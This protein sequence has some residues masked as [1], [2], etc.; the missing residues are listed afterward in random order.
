M[1]EYHLSLKI[2]TKGKATPHFRYITATEKYAAKRGVVHV[3]NGNMPMWAVANPSL[4]WEASDEFE[5]ANGTSYRELEVALPRE[6]AL[7]MQIELARQ[8][9]SEV[10]GHQHAYSFAIHHTKASD[11]GL[12]PHV[13]LQFSE[14][15]QDGVERDMN[16]FFKRANKKAPEK[17]GCVKDRSWQAINQGRQ[18]FGAEA[19]PRL[20]D[21][22]ANWA[23]MCNAA[24]KAHGS[25]ERVDHRSYQARGINNLFPQPKVGAKSWHLH[26]RIGMKNE[27]FSAREDVI[28]C[29]NAIIAEINAHKLAHT[30]QRM[31]MAEQE[32]SAL[33]AVMKPDQSTIL[34]TIAE[35]HERVRR[36]A[37]EIHHLEHVIFPQVYDDMMNVN[38]KRNAGSNWVVRAFNRLYF[39]SRHNRLMEAHEDVTAQ[40]ASKVMERK[41]LIEGLYQHP[42]TIRLATEQ[43]AKLAAQYYAYIDRRDWLTQEIESAKRD[44]D[45]SPALPQSHIQ[46]VKSTP[47]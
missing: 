44:I 29:N 2:G 28:E 34:R 14:R 1:A 9:A 11:G 30:E 22:R 3:E 13:H 19:C 45:A 36:L 12:N 42:D 5:R 39:R 6:L 37:H 32:L 8:L 33:E 40:V 24:L 25:K 35:S 17:G 47:Y 26:K 38:R 18:K 41:H 10:C 46:H 4:Y 21:I 20:L 31:A 16:V 43:Y 15:I 27:R 7:P 23:N